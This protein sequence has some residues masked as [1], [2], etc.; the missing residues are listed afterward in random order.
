MN[1]YTNDELPPKRFIG[2]A[3]KQFHG[4]IWRQDHAKHRPFRIDK[5]NDN[6]SAFLNI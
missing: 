5:I 1:E 4:P 3:R 2:A 6:R